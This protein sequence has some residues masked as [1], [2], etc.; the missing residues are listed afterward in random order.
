MN[1]C[2]FLR[3]VLF[4][5]AVFFGVP[6]GAHPVPD[7]PVRGVFESGGAATIHVEVNP[8]AF[9]ADPTT[10][11]S[12]TNSTYRTLPVARRAELLRQAQE[13]VTRTIEF[14]LEPIGRQQP[15]F[16]FDF[17]GEGH[18]P[19]AG[20]D[21][22][23]VVMGTWKTN[24]PAGLTGW[25]IQATREGKLAIVFQNFID[26]APH[27]R[28]HVLFPGES[29]YTLDLA[30]LAGAAPGGPT[31]GAISREGSR[32][33][34]WFTF[35]KFLRDGFIHVLP[36]GLDHI[37]FVLGLFLLSRAWKPLL[38]QVTMFTLA[39]TL[40]LALA[41]LGWV[42]VP[43]AIVEPIIAASIAF[44]AL[45]NIFHPRYTHWRLLVVF[46]FGLVHGLGFAGALG[47]LDR[48][49]GSLAVR[50]VGFNLGV[51][52]GQLAVIALAFLAT[53]WLRDPA[54]YRRWI[55]VPGSTLIALAG[56]W[57]SI[58]RVFF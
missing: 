5:L 21:D 15:A 55:V 8:R 29:S 6:A 57:W 53:A 11:P 33:D 14:Y 4:A 24:I 16:T 56:V 37:L 46:V 45:E 54:L 36:L 51:E 35:A 48:V 47:D 19:L 44:V 52:G 12:L 25:R 28:V 38:W 58:E 10:A 30:G 40:T 50:L 39:H 2:R 23:V 9:D 49:P 1:A 3:P 32:A 42:K 41:T 27:P 31:P 26:G 7:L 13:L 20:E 17:T 34:L 43:A 18:K 22:V